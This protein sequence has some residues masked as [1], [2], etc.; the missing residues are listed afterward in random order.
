MTAKFLFCTIA[1]AIFLSACGADRNTDNNS[2][3]LMT[4]SS[5]VDTT[6]SGTSDTSSTGAGTP[7]QSTT[8]STTNGP[9][10]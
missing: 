9:E 3:T 2:D 1:A 7:Q 8:D 4:D 10:Q 6:A 5:M